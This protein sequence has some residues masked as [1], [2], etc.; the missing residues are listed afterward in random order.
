MI[1]G[2]T[3]VTKTIGIKCTTEQTSISIRGVAIDKDYQCPNFYQTHTKE[4]SR[5]EVVGHIMSHNGNSES[6]IP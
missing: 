1:C 4:H 3:D 6:T 5:L 2:E